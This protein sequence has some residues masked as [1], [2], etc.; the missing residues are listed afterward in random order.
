MLL[1]VNGTGDFWEP[2]G[3]FKTSNGTQSVTDAK[4]CWISFCPTNATAGYY[5]KFSSKAGFFCDSYTLSPDSQTVSI[6]SM[7]LKSGDNC[8]AMV[9][10]DGAKV[11]AGNATM[12]RIGH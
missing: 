2:S 12:T 5:T 6:T 11:D 7:Q 4:H 3:S 8:S 9:A 10:G 1:V